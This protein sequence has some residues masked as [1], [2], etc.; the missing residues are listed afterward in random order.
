MLMKMVLLLLVLVLTDI[1]NV[2]YYGKF[3]NS[4]YYLNSVSNNNVVR[5]NNKFNTTNNLDIT[6]SNVS[7]GN[8]VTLTSQITSDE[9]GLINEGFVEFYVKIDGINELIGCSPVSVFYC[10]IVIRYK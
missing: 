4:I 5:V 6:S 8:T 9:E 2:T 1:G 7:Y 3:V 10:I